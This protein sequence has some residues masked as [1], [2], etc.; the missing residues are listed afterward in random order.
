MQQSIPRRHDRGRDT[1]GS[2]RRQLGGGLAEESGHLGHLRR[3]R[4][5]VERRASGCRLVSDR[6]SRRAGGRPRASHHGIER[7]A[8]GFEVWQA[9]NRRFGAGLSAGRLDLHASQAQPALD[10]VADQV[11]ILDARVGQRDLPT[12]QHAP[13]HGQAVVIELIPQRAVP[14]NQERS[15]H[16]EAGPREKR[17]QEVVG[18]E[19]RLGAPCATK[20]RGKGAAVDRRRDVRHR[21]EPRRIIH[22][23]THGPTRW[24][25]T[26]LACQ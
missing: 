19:R 24:F 20:H 7:V 18:K 6:S 11:N 8:H 22:V 10:E 26:S 13:T 21:P 15:D 9:F 3:R 4:A 17:Q 14:E 1:R 23:R 25:P 12:E 2:N 16:H 5:A